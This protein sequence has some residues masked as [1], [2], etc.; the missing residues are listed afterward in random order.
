[1]GAHRRPASAR[2]SLREAGGRIVGE[3]NAWHGC[4][5]C[6]VIACT[7]ERGGDA[8]RRLIR[9]AVSCRSNPGSVDAGR[10]GRRGS[11]GSSQDRPSA[12]APTHVVFVQT[13]NTAGNQVVAYDRAADG[14]SDPSRHLQHRRAGRRADRFG[15]RPPG[16]PGLPDLRPAQRRCSTP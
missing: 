10:A 16:L 12:A 4:G 5:D 8:M 15:R 14:S 13:D 7:V 9:L 6:A 1:M 2:E 11:G 3:R